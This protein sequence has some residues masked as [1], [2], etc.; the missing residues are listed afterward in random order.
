M[1]EWNPNDDF[2]WLTGEYTYKKGK[3]KR[4]LN[5]QSSDFKE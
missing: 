3:I 5:Q 4:T 1:E 2:D